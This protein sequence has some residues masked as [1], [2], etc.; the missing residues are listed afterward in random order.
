VQYFEGSSERIIRH[1]LLAYFASKLQEGNADEDTRR[2]DS[3]KAIRR[4]QDSLCH[5]CYGY[6]AG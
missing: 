2:I 5:R 6:Y 3:Q 1:D 4:S